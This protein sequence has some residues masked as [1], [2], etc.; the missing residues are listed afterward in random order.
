MMTTAERAV[1]W[2]VDGTLVDSAAYHFLTWREALAREQFELTRER[3]DEYFGQRNDTILRAYFGASLPDAEIARI[4]DAKESLY[5]EM[6]RDRGIE[7]LPG[8]RHWLERLHTDGWL[9]CVA[10]SAPR[11]N[12]EAIMAALGIAKYFAAVASAEEVTRGK[13]HPDI[14]LAAAGKVS[15]AP[16]RAV[17]VEDAPAGLEGARRAGCHTIGVLTTHVML[18]ADIVVKTLAELSHDAFDKLVPGAV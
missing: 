18:E 1:L 17:V 5:R 13:P 15:V 3:F 4:A 7:P 2:D 10:S 6:I 11:A 9:Q 12:L 16:R 8:V 14:F